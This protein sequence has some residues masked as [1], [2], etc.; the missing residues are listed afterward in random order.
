MGGREGGMASLTTLLTMPPSSRVQSTPPSRVQ[1]TP[2]CSTACSPPSAIPRGMAAW[3]AHTATWPV[4]HHRPPAAPP[5]PFQ[6]LVNLNGSWKVVGDDPLLYA[7]CAAVAADHHVALAQHPPPPHPAPGPSIGPHALVPRPIPPSSARAR[8]PCGPW[9][10]APSL[11]LV[12]G[13]HRRN[14]LH[15]PSPHSAPLVHK[16][17]GRRRPW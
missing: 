11:P 15:P 17:V 1:S 2:P 8:P 14:P 10:D 4:R 6:L 5:P 12:A 7:Q 13:E 16:R 9:L 3:S